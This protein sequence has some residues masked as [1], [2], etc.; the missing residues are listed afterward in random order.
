MATGVRTALTIASFSAAALALASP[1]QA[2]QCV[3][4][5]AGYTAK[6]TWYDPGDLNVTLDAKKTATVGTKTANSKPK[7]TKTIMAGQESCVS[8]P[9]PYLAVISVV[10]GKYARLAIQITAGALVVAGAG[11]V[12]IG[13]GGAG[14][15]PAIELAPELIGLNALIP[16]AKEAFYAN[17]PHD[18]GKSEHRLI[19]SGS[20]FDPKAQWQ[21]K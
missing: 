16:K 9:R 6:V 15:E 17:I 19:L 2:T 1:A 3:L 21:K 10:D 20:V 5:Q 7:T 12:C 4:N 8:G 14:C 18:I 13:T 11:A